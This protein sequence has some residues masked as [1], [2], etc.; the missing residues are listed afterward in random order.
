MKIAAELKAFCALIEHDFADHALLLRAVTH[1][2]MSS[3]T[4][5]DNQRDEFLGDRILGLVIAEAL[6]QADKN[7]SEGVLAPRFN[8]LV[9]K[10]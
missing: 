10:E 8:A 6:L 2:S 7:A 1:S 5:D 9:R 4:R 3:V